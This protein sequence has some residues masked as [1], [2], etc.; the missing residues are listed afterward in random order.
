MDRIYEIAVIVAGIDEEYQNSIIDGI[1]SCAKKHM[2]NVSCFCAFGGVL[3]SRK[4]DIGEYNIY[5]LINYDKFDGVILMSNTISD[6]VEKEKIIN[7]TKNSGLPVTV[8][9][10][11]E[12]PEFYN[13]SIDNFNAMKKLVNHIITVHSS[14]V[15]NYISGPLVNPEAADR[16]NAFLEVMTEHSVTVDPDRIYFGEFRAIDGSNA[17]EEFI[18]S[19]KERPDAIICANDAMAL[20]AVEKLSSFG[21]KVPDDIIVTGF[22]NTYNARHHFPSLT[23]ISRPLED[24]GYKACEVLIDLINGNK[25]EKNTVFDA[26]PVFSES[27]GCAAEEII[28]INK[29]RSDMY[30]TVNICKTDISL[31]NRITTE[32]AENETSDSNIRT[33]AK[34]I[35]EIKCDRFAIC[36]C[37][38]WNKIFTGAESGISEETFQTHGYTEKMSAPLILEKGLNTPV[39]TFSSADMQPAPLSGGGNISYFLPLHF[40]ERCLGYYIFTNTKFPTKSLLCHTLILNISNSIENIS[41]LLHLN[42]MI[43]E[44]N[45][46]YVID[47]LCGIYNRNGFIRAAD[48]LFRSCQERQ[49]KLLISFID[50]DGLKNINDNYGHKEG[51]FSL[52]RLASVIN[53]CCR[54]NKICARFGGDEFII[55]GSDA[56]EEDIS[57]IENEFSIKLSNIN[58]IIKKPYTIE[59]SIGTIVT[60]VDREKTLFNLITQADELMYEK[61]KRKRTSHYLRHD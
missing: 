19:G 51:D 14:K 12:C 3:S 36:L 10:F 49:Q 55:I 1:T 6:P 24:A 61:K 21:Y 17:V 38:N 28:D 11:G 40:R 27:C 42:S 45:R 53:E 29:Y 25:P 13:I 32:L 39:K 9:D 5:S 34:F 41:K 56:C 57:T 33:I 26:V 16:Y 46:L 23:T 47:P 15:I 30:K 44:L 50:M 4:Y 37:H 35:N 31:I 22:D 58:S 52:Q 18:S 8:L 2:V 54:E 60:E 20:A 48:E 59:A 43:V 7:K